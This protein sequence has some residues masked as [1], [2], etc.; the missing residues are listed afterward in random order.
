[1]F[2]WPGLK[3]DV[4]KFVEQCH[5]CQATKYIPTRP[6]GL[7]Q[8]LPIPTRPWIDIS[9]DII[10]Q[11]PKSSGFTAIMVVV[12]RFRKSAHF[13]ALRPRFTSR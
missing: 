2:F 6:Q 5:L 11:L 9:M 10:V 12:D 8:P 1:M 7:L 4:Q 13:E 3:N